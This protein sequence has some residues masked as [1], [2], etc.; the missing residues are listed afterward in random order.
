[1][2]VLLPPSETKVNGGEGPPLRLDA[3]SHP[4]LDP[5]RKELVN[6]LVDLAGDVTASRGAGVH[7]LGLEGPGGRRVGGVGH[8]SLP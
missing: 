7:L 5:V 6:E 4:E 8:S 1:M 2:L 3:L